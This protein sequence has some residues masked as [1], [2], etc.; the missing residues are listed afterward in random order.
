MSPLP[1]SSFDIL[2][3]EIFE[4]IRGYAPESNLE[5]V[6]SAYEF[7]KRAHQGQL[8]RSGE[9][10]L[11][12]PLRTVQ[13]LANLHVDEDTLAA[14]FLHD[15]PEDTQISIRE[16]EKEFG[17]K[18]AYLVDGITKLSKVQYR[19]HAGG[20]RDERQI[21][22]LKK[23][24]IHSAEDLR[25]ILI[26]LAD[27]LDNMRTLRFIAND[28]KRSRIARET[29]EIYVP[30]ANLLGIGEIRAELEDLCFEF[31][32][33]VDFTNLKREI[34]S[35]M[36]ERTFVLQEMIR[37]TEKELQK[38]HI[39]VEIVGRP[40]TLYSIYKK[41]QTKQ[42]IGNIDDLLA[43][44][45][46]VPTRSDCYEILG[47]IHRLF[48]PK[49]GS[50]KDY[51]A[52][53]KPNGYQSLHTTV[54]GIEGSLVEFQIRTRYMHLEAE[55]G[56]A[57]HYFYKYTDEHELAAIMRQRSTWV[58][59]ILEIQK[60]Q[61]DPH[62]FLEHLKLDVFQD[63]IFI[64]SPKGDVI[65]LPRGA[66][67]LDFA[68]AI[69]TDVGIHASK[70]EINGIMFPI[71]ATLGSGDTVRIIGDKDVRP[72]R[73]WLQFVKTSLASAKIKDYLKREPV[74]RKR[75]MGKKFL[76]REFDRIGKNFLDELSTKRLTL[77]AEKTSCK[78]LDEVLIAVGE[79]SLHPQNILEMLYEKN[80]LESHRNSRKSGFHSRVALMVYGNNGQQQFR[81]IVRTLNALHI[82]IVN[83]S[84]DHPWYEKRDRC[85]ITVIV[86]DYH[87]LA[88]VFESLENL[89]GVEKITRLFAQRKIRF[90]VASVF[91]TLLW[92]A[93]PFF[94]NLFLSRSPYAELVSNIL[95]GSG[96][97]MLFVLVWY[98][99]QMARR[100]FPELA[101]IRYY[102]PFLYALNTFAL[103]TIIGEIAIF[104]LQ[105]N[106][107]FVLIL[108]VGMYA[109]LTVRYVRYKKEQ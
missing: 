18:I 80:E 33:P 109:L 64:F 90:A 41:L 32:Y 81:E 78:N 55:Y 84:M 105:F 93:H 44:R 26:K 53:P 4:K 75:A 30:I 12:H 66:C 59:R 16:I 31:L 48:K 49:T 100:S 2:A 91:T 22:S 94:I 7:A 11:I 97:V 40:K 10:Y 103:L 104:K 5:K 58:Q 50:V 34:E 24:F 102:W 69:H 1:A 19:E 82:P 51:I 88:Q 57:A 60:D 62:N 37:M 35:A 87:E 15:V 38:H 89:D 74:E 65:D 106:T 29:L 43:I 28:S 56:I 21:E 8:R 98:L 42:T 20:G 73:E 17:K 63:R 96:F 77:I 3:E 92:I 61:E 23:L 46:I 71:T 14:A 45:I 47:I 36:E 85:R 54:F 101:E 99:K 6:R 86:K 13:I 107:V 9:P 76:Q 67:A 27:R 108:I 52:V 68:Y 95:M 25:V 83:F 70:A 72:E 39:D 79:G